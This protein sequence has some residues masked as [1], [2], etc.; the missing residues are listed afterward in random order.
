VNLGVLI[1]SAEAAGAREFL[2]VG[3]DFH[4]RSAAMGADRWLVPKVYATF[5]E[6]T[7]HARQ[8]GYQLVAVQQSPGAE[9]FDQAA[10]PPRP[11][12]MLGSEGH[13]LPPALCAEADLIVEIPILGRI[14]S[15]NVASAGA[16]VLWATLSSL[17]WVDGNGGEG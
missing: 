3:R 16:I 10:Y 14:D 11:C 4:H 15:L 1:R 13:G 17:G 12:L 9:R 2:I 6:M 5:E 8:G 7:A